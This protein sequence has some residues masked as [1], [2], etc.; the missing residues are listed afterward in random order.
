MCEVRFAECKLAIEPQRW[1]AVCHLPLSGLS[2]HLLPIP[3]TL[4]LENPQQMLGEWPSLFTHRKEAAA[5]Y[6]GP[7]KQSTSTDPD[8]GPGVTALPGSLGTES[9]DSI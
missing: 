4:G 2:S 1:G 5:D 6:L 8:P 7:S 3:T 9:L